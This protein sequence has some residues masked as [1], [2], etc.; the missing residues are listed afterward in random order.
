M[1]NRTERRINRMSVRANYGQFMPGLDGKSKRSESLQGYP[2]AVDH[3]GV[4]DSVTTRPLATSPALE[5]K[6]ILNSGD[7]QEYD[8][9]AARELAKRWKILDEIHRNGV[10]KNG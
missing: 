8:L 6:R 5:L 2:D 9:E 3:P 7:S 1:A 10:S 4:D